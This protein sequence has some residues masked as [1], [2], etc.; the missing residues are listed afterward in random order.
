VGTHRLV[1]SVTAGAE[2]RGSSTGL[3]SIT[4]DRPCDPHYTRTHGDLIRV[5]ETGPLKITDA[6]LG[7]R[8]LESAQRNA[9]ISFTGSNGVSGTLHL[10]DDAVT[11]NR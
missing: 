9:N 6:P 2:S 8:A 5:S 11:V 10:G 1:T 3:L 4:R 7:S